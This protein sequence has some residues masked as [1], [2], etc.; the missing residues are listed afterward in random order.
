MRFSSFVERIGGEGSQAWEI[1]VRAVNRRRQGEDI[2]LLSIG[3]PDFDTPPAIVDA[4]VE[5]LRAGNTHYTGIVGEPVLRR[6]IARHHAAMTGMPTDPEQV[7]VFSG[8][9]NALF[10]TSLCLLDTSDEVISPEPMYVTYEAVIGASGAMMV[11]VPLVRETG[12]H[13]D[14]DAIA[15][16]VTGRT[17]AIMLNTPHNPTGAVYN[18]DELE[19]VA[20]LCRCHDLWLISDEVYATLT[21]EHQHVSPASLPGMADRTVVVSSLSKSH[22]MTGWRIGWAIAPAELVPHLAK[23]TLCMLY[24]APGFIQQAAAHALDEK[25]A[26]LA[27]MK[28]ELRMRRDLVCTLLSGLAGIECLR[29]EGAMFVMLDIRG[30]GLSAHDFAAGLLDRHAV[31]VLP[32]DAFGETARGHLRISLA[33]DRRQLTE[34]CNRIVAYV[35]SLGVS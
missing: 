12:F 8:A 1:H 24:G 5:S 30:T 33:V 9:Q 3:D 18:R 14:P 32:A 17:R 6:A 35:D 28:E 19:A 7:V 13:L 31:A 10:A 20:K 29:P 22:A 26:E 16:A 34:A 25:P 23:L 11:K 21:F 27:E 4:C 2:I 15:A